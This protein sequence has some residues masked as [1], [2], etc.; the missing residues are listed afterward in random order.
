MLIRGLL[1]KLSSYHSS[2][3]QAEGSRFPRRRRPC[4]HALERRARARGFLKAGPGFPLFFGKGPVR[5]PDPGRKFLAGPSTY[6]KRREYCSIVSPAGRLCNFI[7]HICGNYPPRAIS[8]ILWGHAQD[9]ENYRFQK[10]IRIRDKRAAKVI[11]N[12]SEIIRTPTV[13]LYMS[14]FS[15]STVTGPPRRNQEHPE[16]IGKSHKGPKK[17]KS[18]QTSPNRETKLFAP[19]CLPS[20]D[21]S[22]HKTYH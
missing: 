1:V 12:I 6:K 21:A 15:A 10:P 17:D 16:E 4:Q 18:G 5:V 7:A 13:F 14:F 9:A 19:P 2:R 22:K 11:C 20:L 3:K 8:A